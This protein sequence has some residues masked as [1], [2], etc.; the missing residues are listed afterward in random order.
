MGNSTHPLTAADF[1]QRDV[2]T[3]SRPRDTQPQ[4]LTYVDM[5]TF[6]ATF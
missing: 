1:M 2:V 3:L 6:L 5:D 4:E